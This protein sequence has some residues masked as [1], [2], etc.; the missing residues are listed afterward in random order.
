[1]SIYLEPARCQALCYGMG[2]SLFATLCTVACPASVHEFS[3][4]EYWSG[5]SFPSSGDLPDPGIEPGFP[6]V[7]GRCFPGSSDGKVSAYNV[8]DPGS[9]PGLGRS[10]G[11]GTHSSILAWKN[12][13]D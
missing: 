5:L 9:I 2:I 13:M 10:P 6:R 3:R 1:M 4:Q 7:A 12:L 11:V 8:G